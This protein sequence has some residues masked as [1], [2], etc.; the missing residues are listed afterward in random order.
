MFPSTIKKIIFGIIC[1]LCIIP[2]QV[3]GQMREISRTAFFRDIYPNMEKPAVLIFGRQACPATASV[4]NNLS[5]LIPQ[6]RQYVDFFYIDVDV[7]E[8]KQWLLSY[9]DE[10]FRFVWLPGWVLLDGTCDDDVYDRLSGSPTMQEAKEIIE[11][12]IDYVYN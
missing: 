3:Q 1:V 11:D 12:L 5:Q 2:S 8:N 7:K 10:D 4:K 9:N 6:Y